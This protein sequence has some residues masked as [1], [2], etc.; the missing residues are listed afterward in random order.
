[1]QVTPRPLF[2]SPPAPFA[3]FLPRAQP[4]FPHLRD[5][6]VARHPQVVAAKA[7]AV[8][9]LPVL[10]AAVKPGQLALRGVVAQLQGRWRGGGDAASSRQEAAECVRGGDTQ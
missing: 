9:M 4:L 5:E 1:M 2:T 10:E 7:C 6:L 8:E 3:C